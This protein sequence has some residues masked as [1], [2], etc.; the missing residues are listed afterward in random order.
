M[1]DCTEAARVVGAVLSSDD[2][3]RA[4]YYLSPGLTIKATR[5]RRVDKR[6]KAESYIVTVGRPNYAE[7]KFIKVAKAAG[8]PFPVKK[9]QLTFWPKKQ[10][11][12]DSK[13][14]RLARKAKAGRRLTRKEIKSLSAAALGK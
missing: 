4:T 12:K 5:T 14:K 8:E 11:V 6:E 1:F 2:V 3:R 13:V 10:K 7:R 9:V